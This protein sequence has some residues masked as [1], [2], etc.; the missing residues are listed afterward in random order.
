MPV[1]TT[2]R[3]ILVNAVILFGLGVFLGLVNEDYFHHVYT[4]EDGLLEW[5]TVLAL[6]AIAVVLANRLWKYRLSFTWRQRS[7]LAA[8][9]VLA[10]FGAGEEI[11]WGQRLLGIE[12]SEFFLDHNRQQEINL[13]NLVVGNVSVNKDIFSK[14]ILLIFLLYLGVIKPLYHRSDRVA[15]LVDGWGIPIPKR[16]QYLGY[17]LVVVLVEGLVNGVT[18]APRRGELT[19]F[20]I[21]VLAALNLIY[22]LNRW[23]PEGARS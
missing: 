15:R 18:G 23:K 19:E 3:F 22:P 6:G 9:V 8:L 16:Y 5:L 17:L 4:A 12:T 14:G 20:M 2:E 10:T 13:H 11:S 21:P 1:E 7:V